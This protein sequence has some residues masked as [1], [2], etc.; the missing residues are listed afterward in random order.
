MNFSNI[1]LVL[2]LKL[3]GFERTT[4]Y[5]FFYHHVSNYF[6]GDSLIGHDHYQQFSTYD[7]DTGNANCAVTYHGAW[8]FSA[9][10]GSYLNDL[11]GANWYLYIKD[12][13]LN[14]LYGANNYSGLV[15][16]SFGFPQFYMSFTEMKF[17]PM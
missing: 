9:C 13:N 16:K 8:W 2:H 7:H 3:F 17:R 15:W 1:G 14:G 11:H 6:L 5:H 10:P 12:S 4:V